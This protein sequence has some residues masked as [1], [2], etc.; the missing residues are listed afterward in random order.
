MLI[1]DREHCDINAKEWLRY[2]WK[3]YY[4]KTVQNGQDDHF[5]QNDVT[6]NQVLA[7]TR[8]EWTILA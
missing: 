5:G 6:L 1:F 3:V 2:C 8:P 7:F 4:T